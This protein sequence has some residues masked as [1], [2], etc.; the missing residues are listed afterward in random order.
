MAVQFEQLVQRAGVVI[1]VILIVASI[2]GFLYGFIFFPAPHAMVIT[3]IFSGLLFAA[4][5]VVLSIALAYA[6]ALIATWIAA[7]LILG[8]IGGILYGIGYLFTRPT[9]W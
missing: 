8:A 4:A 6:T 9:F 5:P 2:A 7:A 3:R 1:K